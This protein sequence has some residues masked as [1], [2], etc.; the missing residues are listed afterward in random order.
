MTLAPHKPLLALTAHDLMSEAL[1]MVPREM[2]LPMAARLLS[3]A[4]VS[5]APVV[6]DAGR[7]VGVLSATD[8]IHWAENPAA[9]R[10]QPHA[11]HEACAAWQILDT[12]ELPEEAVGRF[13][14]ADPVMVDPSAGIGKLAH[15]MLDAH[16]H[17]VIVVD[18][19]HRPIGIVSATDILA[20]V[21]RA[22]QAHESFT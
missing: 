6:D 7:C 16:I 20:A 18:H 12:D 4:N 9:H 14:T 17:R 15:M 10:P 3:R 21:A 2:S 8:F 1:L 22:E 13:M 19:D 5:G 11:Q